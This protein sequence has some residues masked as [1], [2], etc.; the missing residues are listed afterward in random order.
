M[1]G[2]PLSWGAMCRG[3]GILAEGGLFNLH[4]HSHYHFTSPLLLQP[5]QVTTELYSCVHLKHLL[6]WPDAYEQRGAAPAPPLQGRSG[7]RSASLGHNAGTFVLAVIHAGSF[8]LSWPSALCSFMTLQRRC[9]SVSLLILPQSDWPSLFTLWSSK[10]QSAN[11]VSSN[12]TGRNQSAKTHLLERVRQMAVPDPY[13]P[14]SNYTLPDSLDKV[15]LWL[16]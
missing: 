8:C 7:L 11:S 3:G 1:A 14:N 9:P 2:S 6:W 13:H 4:T 5:L 15:T 12:E 16:Q 10:Y